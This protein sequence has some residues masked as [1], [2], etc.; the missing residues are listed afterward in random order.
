MSYHLP[1]QVLKKKNS[2]TSIIAR[3]QNKVLFPLYLWENAVHSYFWRPIPLNGVA[4]GLGLFFSPCLLKSRG[5]GASAFLMP[6]HLLPSSVLPSVGLHIP[7][8]EFYF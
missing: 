6:Q 7:W 4:F 1:Y 5:E 3:K 8:S 2:H